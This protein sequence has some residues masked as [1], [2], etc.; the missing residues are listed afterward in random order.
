M[1]NKSLNTELLDRAIVFAIL[2]LLIVDASAQT[3]IVTGGVVETAT[4]Q[5]DD[6]TA[7]VLQNGKIAYVG[8]DEPTSVQPVR[9]T[10]VGNKEVRKILH[11]G[12][13]L[14]GGGD[15]YYNTTGTQAKKN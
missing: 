13:V 7:V 12:H 5:K 8:N 6:A 14:I 3:T 2:L 11:D 15:T 9:A 4:G 1:A 10:F